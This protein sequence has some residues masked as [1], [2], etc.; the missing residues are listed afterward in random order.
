M[1]IVTHSRDMVADR[2]A[3]TVR[4]LTM[5]QDDLE[6]RCEGATTERAALLLGFEITQL[7]EMIPE[8]RQLSRN[9]AD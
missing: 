2:L 3:D 8:L 4:V 6:R 1:T 5:V 7:L 9:D